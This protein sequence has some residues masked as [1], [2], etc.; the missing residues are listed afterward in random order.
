VAAD[1][2]KRAAYG[3]AWD[4]IA[5]AQEEQAQFY[6]ERALFESAVAFD[7]ELFEIARTLVRL[8]AEKQK[9]N[10]ERLRE[11]RESN[12]PSLEF[13]LFS[14]APIYESLEKTKLTDSLALMVELLGQ[15]HA[16]VTKVLGG[17]TPQQLAEETV[18]KTLLKDVNGR[19][20][21]AEEG[22]QAIET[23]TDPM[24][25]LALRID[26]DSRALR[27]R[28][29]DHV[30]GVE[31]ANY[32]LIA[33]AIFE[34][35]GTATYPDA[36]FTLR[37]S[38][39]TVKGYQENGRPLTPFTNFRGFYERSAQH[40][41]KP[42]YQLTQRWVERKSKLDLA[43]PF[44]FVS[45]VDIIGGNSGSPVVNRRGELVGLIFDGNIHSLVWNFLYDDEKG[46]A[47]AVHSQGI[48]EALTKIY[49]ADALVKEL[50]GKSGR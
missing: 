5:K 31:R 13:G 14:P 11:Y 23:S 17:K 7:S 49:Q 43:I 32:A 22:A 30:Q 2:K 24:I 41:N 40:A 28:Y 33:K 37:L 34:L 12:L 19:K 25:Q 21:L 29:E 6:R 27:K 39:G 4:A 1:S 10:T 45:T 8:V 47:I 35:K 3:G 18:S 38:Y 26:Q 20:K 36:T 9:P 50:R 16:L 46:R 48:M 15:D 42:P 44:N